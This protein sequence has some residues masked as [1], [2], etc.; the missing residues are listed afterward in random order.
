MRALTPFTITTAHDLTAVLD[1]VHEEGHALVDGEL[2]EGLRSVAVPVR[3]RDGSCLA[4]INVTMHSSRGSTDE[5][6][7]TILPELRATAALIEADLHTAQ[8]F[9]RIPIA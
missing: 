7:T 6:V 3:D 2:E 4:A 5:C 8:R 1:L 9:V